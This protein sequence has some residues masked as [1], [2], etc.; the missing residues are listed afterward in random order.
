MIIVEAKNTLCL[1]R[2]LMLGGETPESEED[3]ETLTR[4]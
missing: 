1:L 2:D 4:M 3:R